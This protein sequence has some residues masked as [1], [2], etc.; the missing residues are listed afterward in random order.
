MPILT[1]YKKNLIGNNNPSE[2][3]QYIQNLIQNISN[4]TFGKSQN[5]DFVRALLCSF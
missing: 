5:R 4:Q 3:N 2:T 1:N